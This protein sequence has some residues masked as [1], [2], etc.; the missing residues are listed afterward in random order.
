MKSKLIL[1]ITILLSLY[2][3]QSNTLENQVK[4]GSKI[5][6][7]QSVIESK[8][9]TELTHYFEDSVY[10]NLQS[11]RCTVKK[12]GKN[13]NFEISNED[14]KLLTKTMITT[15][16]IENNTVTFINENVNSDSVLL[17]SYNFIIKYNT[18]Y[19]L[20]TFCNSYLYE[21]RDY[22]NVWVKGV[23][24]S[25]DNYRLELHYG[26]VEG[27]IKLLRTKSKVF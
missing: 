10:F 19:N 3:C 24:D 17:S 16:D 21:K 6:D 25:V 9:N 18:E 27:R 23:I 8:S 2:S 20:K 5:S 15:I 22:D 12:F 11:R 7:N 14:S 26:N 4:K 1:I 13:M